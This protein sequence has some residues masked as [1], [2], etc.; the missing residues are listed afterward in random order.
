MSNLKHDSTFG[1]GD[2]E[3]AAK[4]QK[5]YNERKQISLSD[6]FRHI[7]RHRPDAARA[8]QVPRQRR[9]GDDENFFT[10]RM[11][12]RSHPG[13]KNEERI[14]LFRSDKP[15]VVGKIVYTSSLPKKKKGAMSDG[16]EL[17]GM[18][19]A[20]IQVLDLKSYYRGM[21]LG[22]LLFHEAVN[23]LKQRYLLENCHCQLDAE[24]DIRRHNKLI[25]F[26]EKLG[27]SVKPRAKIRFL[28]NNDGETYRSV[29]MQIAIGENS[30][31]ESVGGMNSM[32]GQNGGFLPVEFLDSNGRRAVVPKEE[33]E[34][35]PSRRLEWLI[36]ED[37]EKK[38]VI[39][40]TTQGHK[41]FA[42]SDGKLFV[43]N[44][45]D[46]DDTGCQKQGDHT[47]MTSSIFTMSNI[48]DGFG[49]GMGEGAEVAPTPPNKEL[50][51]FQTCHGSYLSADSKTM[52]LSCTLSP[53]F[54]QADG[55][56]LTIRCTKDTPPRRQHYRQM[57]SK[58][59]VQFVR[60]MREKYLRFELGQ[61]TLRDALDAVKGVKRY[62]FSVVNDFGPSLRSFCFKFADVARIRGHPDWFQLIA[63]IAE[64]GRIVSNSASTSDNYDWTLT[65]KS[66]VMGCV[67]SEHTNFS[68]F[69]NLDPDRDNNQ[70]NTNQGMYT[71]RCGFE[72]L[73]LTWTGPEYMYHMLKHNDTNIPQEGL[74]I[75][76]YFQLTDWFCHGNDNYESFASDEDL[77]T[78]DMVLSFYHLRR[79]VSDSF[80]CDE[81]LSDEDCQ[82]RWSAF[83][84]EI[85]RKY[86]CDGVL[87]W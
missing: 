37:E 75:L 4:R 77:E 78:R 31:A 52:S 6:L 35:S 15:G 60:D 82:K 84:Q 80:S 22:G 63:L 39:F 21:D 24:E 59:S 56:T 5:C 40:C 7:D 69:R 66:R 10:L 58:Q 3:P 64:L 81:E 23:R 14:L 44:S 42:T 45:S 62:P 54:W 16:K 41:L 71:D 2:D 20:K 67:P 34:Y 47:K 49:D 72:N 18:A 17:E 26:Y 8:P 12:H 19:Q 87:N 9:F 29:P 28:N 73:L 36:V 13:P 57:W 51:L 32:L 53:H 55:T 68:E 38:G 61:R 79:E 86:G 76:R 25:N 83:Y 27:C 46:Y 48:S 50:W 74:M 11:E 85:A 33:T 43:A 65:S 30:R 70:Y 1:G